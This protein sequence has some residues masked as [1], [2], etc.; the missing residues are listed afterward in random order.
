M[1]RISSWLVEMMVVGFVGKCGSAEAEADRSHDLSFWNKQLHFYA[2]F[3][4]KII[5]RQFS[6]ELKLRINQRVQCINYWWHL[7]VYV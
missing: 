6:S 2:T 3:Q 1:P 7:V 5:P 4:D